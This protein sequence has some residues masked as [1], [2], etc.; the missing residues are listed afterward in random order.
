MVVVVTEWVRVIVM[1]VLLARLL[2]MP[3][4]EVGLIV[5]CVGIVALCSGLSILVVF[6]TLDPVASSFLRLGVE[7]AA[8][9]FGFLLGLVAVRTLA[10]RLPSIRF[11]AN[12]VPHFSRLLPAQL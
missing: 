3:T 4:R 1:S 11:L 8:G 5:A 9:V 10:A 12:R 7:I 6:R 2:K